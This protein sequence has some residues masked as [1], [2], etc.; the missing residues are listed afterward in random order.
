MNIQPGPIDGLFVIEPK[1]FPDHRGFFFESFNEARLREAGIELQWKQDNHVRSVR[2]TVR[3]LHFQWGKGQAKLI[4]CVRGRVWDV[5]VDIRPDSP[6]LGKWH[7]IELSEENKRIFFIPV[8]FAHGYAVLSDEAE[9]LYK[10]SE[11]YDPKMEDGIRWNDPELAVEWPIAH[12][13]LSERDQKAVS[14]REYLE[15]AKKSMDG[16]KV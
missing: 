5:A 6:T 15:R 3:G 7:G 8:G 12:P 14:F 2:D 1:V 16:A 11:L 9:T 10:C 4:R 13:L